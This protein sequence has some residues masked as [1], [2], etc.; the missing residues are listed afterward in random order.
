MAALMS[1]TTA[2]SSQSRFMS[3]ASVLATQKLEELNRYPISDP[4]VAVTGSSA[5]SITADTSSGSLNYFDDVQISAVG[6]SITSTTSDDLGNYTTIVQSPDG[7]ITSSTSP[8]APAPPAETLQFHRRWII[9][10]DVPIAGVRRVTVF[11]QLTNPPVIKS[12]TF[13]ISMVRP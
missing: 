3:S 9:E 8:T 4:V 6:G 13:Q 2:S 5:G 10:K 11:V 12:V 7:T 1:K